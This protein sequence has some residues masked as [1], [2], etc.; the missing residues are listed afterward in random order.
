MA[1]IDKPR[2]AIKRRKANEWEPIVTGKISFTDDEK[3]MMEAGELVFELSCDLWEEDRFSDDDLVFSVGAI[4][5]Y[6]GAD[7]GVFSRLPVLAT[8]DLDQELGQ[9]EIYA[10]LTLR[11]TLGPGEPL[12]VKS[13]VIKRRFHE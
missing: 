5:H 11:P 13:N 10:R 3:T 8:V 7:E 4:A 12:I 9:E 6:P 1:T 2:L